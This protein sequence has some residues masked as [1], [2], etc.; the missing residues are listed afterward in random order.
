MNILV[1]GGTSFVGNALINALLK[2]GHQIANVSRRQVNQHGV[3]NYAFEEDAVAVIA[4]FC[5]DKVVYMSSI[6]DNADTAKMLDINIKKPLEILNAMRVSSCSEFI[7]IGSYWQF[8]DAA[9]P[10]VAIDLYSASKKAIVPFLDYYNGYTHLCCK[11]IVLYGSYAEHDPRHKLIDYLC[12]AVSRGEKLRLTKGE[13][14]LNLSHVND[15]AQKI[16]EIVLTG[17][18]QKYQVLSNKSYQLKQIIQMLQQ[19]TKVE[20]ELG[21]IEYR[22][23]E[24]MNIHRDESYLSVFIEDR[25]AAFLKNKMERGYDTQY[26]NCYSNL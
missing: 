10:N 25:L 24:L 11:E 18:K 12:D 13:Q 16:S 20:V 21:A 19:Y 1:F 4:D 8:G 6:F 7:Y 22:N 9:K 23:V 2:Q 14:E 17:T 5:P 15:I 26:S 3:S